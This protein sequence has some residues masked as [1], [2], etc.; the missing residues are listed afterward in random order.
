MKTAIFGLGTIVG[1]EL[2]CQHFPGDPYPAVTFE[3]NEVIINDKNCK[4]LKDKL[5]TCTQPQK[6]ETQIFGQITGDKGSTIST[7]LTTTEIPEIQ[8]T[9]NVP[10]GQVSQIMGLMNFL[11]Q[12]YQSLDLQIIATDG[13]MSETELTDHVK[14]TLKQLG[15]N[16]EKAIIKK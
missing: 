8:I 5:E 9:I 11:Q 16:P 3:E 1:E 13:T 15:I 4:D 2:N 10:R 14:E 12:K 6:P 7:P